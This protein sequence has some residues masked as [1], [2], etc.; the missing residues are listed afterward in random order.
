MKIETLKQMLAESI[1]EDAEATIACL[2]EVLHAFC[3]LC[4]TNAL[5]VKLTL[6]GNEGEEVFGLYGIKGEEF[7]AKVTATVNELEPDND[8]IKTKR[9]M[10]EN[11]ND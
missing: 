11:P 9:I 1:T 6:D 4:G 10:Q 8:E 2:G 3:T 7:I 5:S